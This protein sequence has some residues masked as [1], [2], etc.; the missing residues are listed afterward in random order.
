MQIQIDVA[1][2]YELSGDLRACLAF[3]VARMPVQTVLS[4]APF[5][6]PPDIAG[7]RKTPAKPAPADPD[8]KPGREP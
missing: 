7:E 1:M 2:E 4:P 5:P 8:P 6:R 3:E